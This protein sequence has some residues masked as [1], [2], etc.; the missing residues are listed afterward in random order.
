MPRIIILEGP[1]GSGKTTLAERLRGTHGYEIIHFSPPTKGE[2][3][4]KTYLDAL[5]TAKENGVK[6][7]FDRLHLS[8]PI[9]GPIMRREKEPGLKQNAK[10]IE[11]HSEAMDAQVVL[12][13]PPW[14]F[15]LRNWLA[16]RENEYVDAVWK[17]EKIWKGYLKLLRSD[18][19]YIWFDYTRHRV[20][21][22]AEALAKIEGN[23]LPEGV[24]GS[25]APRF[26][27]VGAANL[28]LD[29][30]LDEAGFKESEMAFSTNAEAEIWTEPKAVLYEGQS[31]SQLAEIRRSTK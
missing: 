7:V 23:P 16:N 21:A 17:M 25:Q 5:Q 13:L 1:D 12:C 2:D 15:V 19:P 29:R 22:F 20:G 9:Y 30:K 11:R 3:L 14:R 26:L 27:I 8:E 6:T 28:P 18:R 10:I 31:V 4:R 24:I